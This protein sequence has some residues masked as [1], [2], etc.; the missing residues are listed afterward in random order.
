VDGGVHSPTNADLVRREQ[1][2]LLVVSSPMSI[3]RSVALNRPSRVARGHFRARLGQELRRVRR[4]GVQ[5]VAY[6]PDEDDL[7]VMGSRTMDPAR[8]GAV[9]EQARA[10]TLRRL[11]ERPLP[12][13]GRLT[14]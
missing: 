8:A 9:F 7:A 6:Q 12:V 14:D 4:A 13:A 1:L 10:T 11:A 2:D 5:V 3:S